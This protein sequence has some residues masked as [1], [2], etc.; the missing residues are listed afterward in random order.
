SEI[1]YSLAGMNLSQSP[2]S[3]DWPGI[4]TIASRRACSLRSDL[5]GLEPKTIESLER[6]NH[7]NLEVSKVAFVTRGYR[8]SIN[9]SCGSDHGIFA[10]GIRTSMHEA[11]I[12][13]EAGCVHG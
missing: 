12:F 7:G 4:R 3:S 10:Y 5:T 11:R 8:Q 13:A 2:S 9:E 1:I 6:I